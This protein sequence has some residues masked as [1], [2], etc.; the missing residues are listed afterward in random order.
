MVS[1][2]G[3]DIGADC[4]CAVADARAAAA[5]TPRHNPFNLFIAITSFILE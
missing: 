5:R 4:A 2:F 3:G 1:T